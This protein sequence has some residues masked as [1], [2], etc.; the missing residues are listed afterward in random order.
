MRASHVAAGISGYVASVAMWLFARDALWSTLGAA[1]VEPPCAV[2]IY[3][4]HVPPGSGPIATK[5][6]VERGAQVRL[7]RTRYSLDGA[8]IHEEPGRSGWHRAG[9]YG[10]LVEEEADVLVPAWVRPGRHRL[11]AGVDYEWRYVN[12][13]VEHETRSLVTELDVPSAAAAPFRRLGSLASAAAAALVMLAILRRGWK[14]FVAWL[15]EAETGAGER[16]PNKAGALLGPFA[17]ALIVIYASAGHPLF[18][19]PLLAA[20]GVPHTALAVVYG[21]AWMA[22]PVWGVVLSRRR[23]AREASMITA[24]VTVVDREPR[25]APTD[26]APGYRDPAARSV[27]PPRK[28]LEHL[29]LA[30]K[31]RER[32]AVRRR[33]DRLEPGWLASHAVRIEAHDGDDLGAG[34]RVEAP[35]NRLPGLAEAIREVA[36][37][38]DLEVGGRVLRVDESTTRTSITAG[39]RG[40]GEAE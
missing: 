12:G 40:G 5:V 27:V 29:A 3:T 35:A 39:L 20:S 34:L 21:V 6:R 14:P 1:A 7:T 22:V 9:R 31:R 2:W 25:L 16:S 8:T 18:V 4:P 15:N 28:T 23:E 17:I 36:G 30:L 33:G 11:V 26:G 13:P 32:V 38:I 37:A 10:A 19:K 24:R